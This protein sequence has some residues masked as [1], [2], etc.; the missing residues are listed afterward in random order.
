MLPVAN[1]C[2]MKFNFMAVNLEYNGTS[3]IVVPFDSTSS[4]IV[5][6]ASTRST[7]SA[8]SN[9]AVVSGMV[10]ASKMMRLERV[11]PVA[12]RMIGLA[13]ITVL[14][15]RLFFRLYRKA[16]CGTWSAS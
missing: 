14:A 16:I 5:S 1:P 12:A 9:D 2:A 11:T 15:N 7:S 10:S 4:S 6:A 8:V 13:R 3:A